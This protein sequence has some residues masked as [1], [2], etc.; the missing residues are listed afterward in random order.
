[1][2][3][4]DGG[5]S[6]DDG[7]IACTT[8]A[9]L[10]RDYYFPFRMTKRIPYTDIRAVRRGVANG[11]RIWGSSDFIHWYNLD[12]DRPQKTA[13]LTL[14]TGRFIKPVITPDDPSALIAELT[15]HGVAI[16]R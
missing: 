5:N 12:A 4:N 6:Y 3:G 13:A 1:M 15:S 7:K 10:I 16:A 9:V 8:A 2:S 11:G 14:D